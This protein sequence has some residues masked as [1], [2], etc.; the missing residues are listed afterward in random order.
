MGLIAPVESASS[1]R[2]R[3]ASG[4]GRPGPRAILTCPGPA[5]GL[6]LMKRVALTLCAS[7]LFVLGCG[8]KEPEV[9]AYRE[10]SV[11][12]QRP[13][14]MA[15]TPVP[16]AEGSLAWTA[17]D[18]W[19]EQSGSQMRLVTFKVG[20]D[21][22]ECTI[23]MFPGEVGGLEANLRRWLG[24]LKVEVAD[25]DLASF[26]RNPEAVQSEGSLA[27]QVFDF[28]GLVPTERTDSL[29]AAVVPLKGSTAFV[30]FT[31]SKRLLASEKENFLAL[32][33][34]LKP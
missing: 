14:D 29:L 13:V 16:T 25:T 23:T 32:C 8:R 27:C 6:P 10:I 20:P 33:R 30:K 11:V 19:V 7:L 2:A 31:G 1:H 9:R 5:L 34:S 3:I 18:G 21:G 28:A 4:K 15:S 12:P 17:P 22:A 26:A 24:Q